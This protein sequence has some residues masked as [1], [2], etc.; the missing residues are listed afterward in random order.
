[1]LKHFH[2]SERIRFRNM[3]CL[4]RQDEKGK[5]L[6][7]DSSS[8]KDQ[9]KPEEYGF[10]AGEYRLYLKDLSQEERLAIRSQIKQR[11]VQETGRKASGKKKP[12]RKRECPKE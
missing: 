2:T 3:D 6:L 5:Y 9:T 1:M 4:L 7:P 11:I 10:T 8:E 12:D